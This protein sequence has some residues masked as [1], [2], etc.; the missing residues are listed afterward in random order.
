MHHMHISDK[1]TNEV[2]R[3]SH[4]GMLISLDYMNVTLALAA[5]EVLWAHVVLSVGLSGLDIT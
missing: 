3:M 1:Q 4:R 2:K 5:P